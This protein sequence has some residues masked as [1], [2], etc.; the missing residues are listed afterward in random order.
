MTL[1]GF[2]C[3]A[4]KI[5]GPVP[6]RVLLWSGAG[7]AR[8][9]IFALLPF[10]HLYSGGRPIFAAPIISAAA[11]R[12]LMPVVGWCI[13]V[14]LLVD[15]AVVLGEVVP[16]DLIVS[17]VLGLVKFPWSCLASA[18]HMSVVYRCLFAW[19]SVRLGIWFWF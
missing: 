6:V 1:F 4:L 3:V 11:S 14:L 18:L 15:M 8:A 13:V 9:L 7:L 17:L 19:P 12:P 10:V 5:L 16:V 2:R